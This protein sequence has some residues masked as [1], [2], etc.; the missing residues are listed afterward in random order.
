[1]LTIGRHFPKI[2]RHIVHNFPGYIRKAAVTNIIAGILVSNRFFYFFGRINFK[3]TGALGL[4]DPFDIVQAIN[5]RFAGLQPG[6]VWTFNNRG[7]I[8]M[9]A[10]G[11]HH[12]LGF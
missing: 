10:F 7:A 1:M 6:P 2:L 4:G 9:S 11:D 5:G 12:A 8:G 3:L